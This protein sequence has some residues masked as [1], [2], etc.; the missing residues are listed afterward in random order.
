MP[1]VNGLPPGGSPPL[2]PAIIAFTKTWGCPLSSLTLR[3]SDKFGV[4]HT[5]VEELIAA[6][7]STL[8]YLGLIN[9][10][11]PWES[12]RAIAGKCTRLERLAFHIP[13]KEFVSSHLRVT[14]LRECLIP[15]IPLSPARIRRR[16]RTQQ[17]SAGTY[18]YRRVARH[19]WLAGVHDAR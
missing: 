1:V 17:D 19:A 6:H 12:V 15:L 10:D 3:L 13:S 14:H 16:A 18:R 11:V 9:V 5:F 8:E 2:W 4:S 7:G